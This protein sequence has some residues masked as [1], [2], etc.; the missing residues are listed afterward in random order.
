MADSP[1]AKAG[2]Q[3]GDVITAVDGEKITDA[4]DLSRTIAS[5]APGTNVDLTVNRNGKE[6]HVSVTLE[7][8]K[9]GA[10]H[11][12]ISTNGPSQSSLGFTLEAN[13]NGPGV[14]VESVDPNGIAAMRGFRAGDVILEVNHQKVSDADEV[15]EQLR[16]VQDS[17]RHAVLLKVQ[18]HGQVRFVGLPLSADSNSD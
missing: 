13:D 18:R 6:M 14:V 16:V 17:G 1:A 12:V 15:E 10:G 2:I 5:K 8:L 4:L 7:T 9:G 11:E 3:S